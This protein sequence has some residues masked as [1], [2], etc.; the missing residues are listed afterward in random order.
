MCLTHVTDRREL[1]ARGWQRVE[2]SAAREFSTA[3]GEIIDIADSRFEARVADA[4]P[5]RSAWAR[6]FEKLD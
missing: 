5:V 6:T 3:L 2:A 1:M 4:N